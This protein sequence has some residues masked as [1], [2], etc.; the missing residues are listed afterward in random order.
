MLLTHV[1][2]TVRPTA[3]S[4]ASA[5]RAFGAGRDAQQ[6]GAAVP[7]RSLLARTRAAIRSIPARLAELA[8]G[9]ALG[10]RVV[11]VVPGPTQVG[12]LRRA[13]LFAFAGEVHAARRGVVAIQ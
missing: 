9:H 1:A 11:A 4:L 13:A 6:A 12:G 5:V 10:Q 7:E 3:A 2:R 8:V